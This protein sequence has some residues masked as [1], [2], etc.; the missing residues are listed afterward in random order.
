MVKQISP[1]QQE[2]GLEASL[3]EHDP[4][5]LADRLGIPW[6]DAINLEEMDPE[7]AARATF[8]FCKSNM[9]LPL[10][11][12]DGRLMAASSRPLDLQSVED[13]RLVYGMPVDVAVTDEQ[14]LIEAINKTFD[15]SAHSADEVMDDIEGEADLDTLIHGLPQDLLEAS[16]EA[17]VIR[18]VNSLL[19]QA[20]KENASDIHIEPYERELIVRFRVDGALRN[21]IKPPRRLQA[22]VASRIKIMAKLDIAEKRLPQDG[23]IKII[24]AGKEVDIRVSA[25]PTA[26]G[27][28]IVMRLLDKSRKLYDLETI[29]MRGKVLENIKQLVKSP[30][31]IILVCGKTGS[32]KTTS[33]YA[34]LS[35][36]NTIEK[37]II[38]VEDPIEYQLSG[39]GQMQVNPKI[40]L[41]FA[42]GLRSIL[43]Q[44]PDVIMVGEIRDVETARISVQASLTGHLVFSTVHTNDAA[45]AVARMLDM[46]VEPFLISSS[47][48]AALAQRL[49]RVLCP[50]CREGY[51]PGP[52]HF[53]E[54]RVNPSFTK[55]GARFYR[56]VGCPACRMTGYTGRTGIY[57]L[58]IIDDDIR[59]QIVRKV[60][61]SDIKRVAEKKGF[62]GMRQYGLD[63]VT[64]GITSLEEVIRETS[65]IV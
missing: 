62:V 2:N 50:A 53:S 57:E 35:R 18:L 21:V 26:N 54:M 25:I 58:L 60:N 30:H 37:N 36:I 12:S 44:D 49:V 55:P 56:A 40:G 1:D 42:A 8:Q 43:R 6:L 46:G 24:I 7:L 38:T 64:Q 9:V 11:V 29:G 63:L 13:L 23:R 14:T 19:V 61:S 15:L 51:A 34:A 47:L 31:G 16:A 41:D 48:L 22:L 5:S 28:R 52:E 59:T 45:G 33:L 3:E 32:G 10:R 17:P 4:K 27:E 65:D 20:V 39:V